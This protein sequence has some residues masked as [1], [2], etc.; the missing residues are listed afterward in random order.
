MTIS[1]MYQQ[2]NLPPNL[3]E[4]MLRVGAVVQIMV[5]RWKGP[6]IDNEAVI[7][8]GLNHDLAN[9][10]KFDFSKPAMMG[11]EAARVEYWRSVQ[12]EVIEVYGEDIHKATMAMAQK[13]GLSK[14]TL[15]II[16]RLEWDLT[17]EVLDDQDWPVAMGIYADMRVGPFGIL[18]VQERIDNLH[19]RRLMKNYAWMKRMARRLE[20]ELQQRVTMPLDTINDAAVTARFGQLR[21]LQI[22]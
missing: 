21:K 22:E 7:L 5:E 4:H 3:Q 9:I 19:S 15:K 1:E 11:E 20:E 17:K 16:E 6:A 2:L 18:T 10:I 13:A 8:A 14:G 12:R